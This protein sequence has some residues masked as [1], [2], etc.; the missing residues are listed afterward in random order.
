MG[1]VTP[2]AIAKLLSGDLCLRL[3]NRN[4]RKDLHKQY[5][6]Q[7]QGWDIN[8][9]ELAISLAVHWKLEVNSGNQ[10]SWQDGVF[11]LRVKANLVICSSDGEQ[12]YTR[13]RQGWKALHLFE[14]ERKSYVRYIGEFALSSYEYRGGTDKDQRSRRTIVFHM[15]PVSPEKE[16]KETISESSMVCLS[17]ADDVEILRRK[18]YAAASEVPESIRKMVS[19]DTM[20]VVQTLEA[21]SWLDPGEYVRR[22]INQ[23]PSCK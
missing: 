9:S 20:S 12:S 22:L 18:A 13:S 10:D 7:S 5:G 15:L 2:K 1:V 4:R 23:L 21:M 19:D 6:G 8:S 16:D 17:S 14:Q 3:A 11:L